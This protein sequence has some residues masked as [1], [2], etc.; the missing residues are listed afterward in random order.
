[1]AAGRGAALRLL[2][3]VEQVAATVRERSGVPACWATA[4][5]REEIA[6]WREQ[7]LAGGAAPGSRD[8]VARGALARA[9]EHARPSL[10]W[11]VN[12]TGV[13]LHT[14]LGRAPL[15]AQAVDAVTDVARGYT[16]LEYDLATGRRGQRS[17]H[18]ERLLRLLTGAEAAH[19][20]NNN[21][22]AVL[23]ALAATAAGNEVVISRGELIEIGGSF[24][25]PEILA[26]SG[27]HLV[28]VGTTN[29]TRLSD[30]ERGI[31][32]GTRALLHVH[33]SNFRMVGF[34]EQV[35]IAAL[36][37][38][39]RERGLALIDD[40]GSGALTPLDDEPLLRASVAAGASLACCSAD[41]LLGGPQAGILVG[42]H[43]AV[44]R[45]RRHPL[46]RALRL[47]KLQLAA[48][49][50]TLRLHLEGSS[51]IPVEAMLR[52]EPAL[53]AHRAA[54]MADAIGPAARVVRDVARPGGGTLPLA[55]LEGPVCA[56][57]PGSHGAAAL[58]AA[59]RRGDPPVVARA[60]R[61]HVLLD[62]RTMTDDE[63]Q[64]AAAA[65][66]RALAGDG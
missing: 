22:A 58:L 49:E 16:N 27:A 13:V 57:E 55:E 54:A 42:A 29:R 23:L 5:A 36:A 24:R 21:A 6:A 8:A 25:V 41:K 61:R 46:A 3:A 51:H 65:V 66:A 19:V 44:E 45:C 2:P 20:V 63:A 48:L 10:R 38:L 59:L 31:G 12:A 18:V 15:A 50:A 14:N 35:P 30:Y 37:Q 43:A 52:A 62:P 56:V 28:E 60:S 53:L 64:Q 33:Q 4:G 26:L 47:D 34:V 1:V 17:A 9:R 39:A 40:L 7:M 32:T 11:V